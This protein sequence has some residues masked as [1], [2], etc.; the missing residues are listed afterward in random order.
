M[1]VST[2]FAAGYVG[3]G[4]WHSL[5]KTKHFV[6][7]WSRIIFLGLQLLVILRFVGISAVSGTIRFRIA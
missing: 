5:D 1:F 7:L 4:H 6:K 2:F 3:N